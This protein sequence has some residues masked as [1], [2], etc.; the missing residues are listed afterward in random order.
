MGAVVMLPHRG[1]EE[2]AIHLAH[3]RH[4]VTTEAQ[5]QTLVR[6]IMEPAVVVVLVEQE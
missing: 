1:L 6:L 3:R 5:G 4:R 2:V